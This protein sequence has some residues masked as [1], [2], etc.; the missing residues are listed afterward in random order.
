MD[1]SKTDREFLDN[2]KRRKFFYSF[3]IFLILLSGFFLF[4]QVS[5]MSSSYLDELK[6]MK[7]KKQ[8]Q[9]VNYIFYIN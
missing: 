8:S 6:E 4:N 7:N 1:G 9:K 3:I 2:L 5:Y